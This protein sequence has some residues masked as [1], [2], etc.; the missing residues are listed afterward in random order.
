[1][2]VVTI[3]LALSAALLAQSNTPPIPNALSPSPSQSSRRY[4]R[5]LFV[6]EATA[7]TIATI[8]DGRS[9]ASNTREGYIE[10]STPFLIGRHPTG[11]RYA[12]VYG[13]I[14]LATGLIAYKL[15]SNRRRWVRLVG[16]GIMWGSIGTHSWG[17]FHNIGLPE[18]ISE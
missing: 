18:R 17:Y 3:I 14:G 2:R 11:P 6:L 16:H 9:T 12:V 1:M 13:S 4:P 7:L 10:T 5:A 15:E 8:E